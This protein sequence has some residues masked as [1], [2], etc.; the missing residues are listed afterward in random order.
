MK[1]EVKANR[2]SSFMK[3]RYIKKF[4]R[5]Y[6]FN[7]IFGIIALLI[8]DIVQTR[9]PIIVG[10]VIDGIELNNIDKTFI[11]QAILKLFA[12]AGTVYAGRILWRYFIF[13]TSRNIERD[14][15]NDLFSH[16]E[17]MSAK[18]YQQHGTGEIMAHMTNDLEAVRMT[19]GP[20]ILTLFDVVALGSITIYNMITEIDPLLTIAA[21]VPLMLIAVSVRFM[22]RELQSRF[23]KK[24]E[25]FADL[26]NFVQENLSGIKVVKS[27]VQESKSISSFE[28]WTKNTYDKNIKLSIIQTLMHPFMQMISGT[29]LAVAIGY[30]G[31]ITIK[32][33]IT[34]GEFSAFI[35][36]L[37]MLVWPMMATGI[38]INLFNT[39]A[40]SLE[41]VEKILNEPVEIA[42][43]ATSTA[44]ESLDGRI[45]IKN[46]SYKYPH[47]DRYVLSDITFDVEKGQTL[48]IIGRTGSG[49]TT[50]VNLMLRIF[51]PDEG[52]VFIGN[53]DI[54]N[55]TLNVLRK[56]IGYVPQD[57]FLFSDTIAN[58][59]DFGVRTKDMDKIVE[60][61]KN[62]VVHDNIIEFKQG[63][64]TLVGEKGVS[65]SGGQKQR[66]SIARAMI[67]D[68]EILILDDS[69]SAVDTDTEEKILNHLH[70]NRNG[71][72]N[73]I[74]A[75]RISTIQDADLIIVLDDGKIVEK[76]NHKQLVNLKGLYNSIYEKQLLEKMLE[77]QE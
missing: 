4:F 65:I 52:T 43:S 50:L 42:D 39:G 71:K 68:P 6:L 26:S 74:I 57:N 8:V 33:R 3:S 40:A 2:P 54:L 11:S 12:I 32:G 72:T 15:R 37:G 44:A 29:A 48:G 24:Q 51:E 53:V 17:K 31:Y 18:F 60:A 13:G 27:F 9:V 67:K 34:L 75:H 14:I 25:S 46:L 30:G 22:G 16:L 56:N 70:E 61:A 62:A 59:I 19:L 55:L 45:E 77:D 1:A 66:I 38:T 76:G 64:D 28:K 58:N 20:G 35:Q 7:Y 41:R 73:I 47:T 69:V 21:V 23:T 63:Y 49:K 36:Y 10:N 5:K